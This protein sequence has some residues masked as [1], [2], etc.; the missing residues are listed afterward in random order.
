MAVAFLTVRIRRLGVAY[1]IELW[2]AARPDVGERVAVRS[3]DLCGVRV[4][5]DCAGTVCRA[6]VTRDEP[7]G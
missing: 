2:R 1:R 7:P 4:E 3:A 5:M 6:T